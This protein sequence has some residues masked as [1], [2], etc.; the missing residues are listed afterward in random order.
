MTSSSNGDKLAAKSNKA[1]KNKAG[2]GLL[3]LPVWAQ[4]SA[5]ERYVGD[6]IG[7]RVVAGRWVRLMCQRHRRDLDNGAAR[8]LYFDADAAQDVLDWFDFLRHSK[9]EMAGEIISLEPWQQALLWVLFGWMGSDG[10]RRFRVSY[11][12]MARK[13]GKSTIAA[14]IGLYLLLGDGEP[15]AEVYSAAT[16]R[17]Q[18]KIVFE[19]A[20]RMVRS[21]PFL[22]KKI[23]A[24]RENLHIRDTASKFEA[25]GRDADTMDGLNPHGAILDELHAWRDGE[26][27]GVLET[28]MGARRQ[29]LMFAITTAG[30]NQDSYCFQLRDYACKV[31]DGIVEDD[32][33]FGVIYTLDEGDDWRNEATWIKANPNLGVSIQIDELRD[34][35]VKA[36]SIASTL[37]HFLTKRMNVWTNAA[38]LWIHPDKWRAC[39]GDFDAGRLAGRTCYGGLDLS[40]T[41]DLTAF[42][43]VFTP[44]EDDPV[45]RV[46]PFFWAPEETVRS[47]SRASRVPY[48]VW[49]RDGWMVEIPGEVIDYAY[50]YEQIG[51]AAGLY[52]LREVAFDRWGAAEVY[53][54]MAE[55]GLTMVQLGQG[56]QSMSPPM[57]ELERLITSKLL[58]HGNHPVLT[59]N[60]HNL[61]ATRDAAGNIKPDKRK[62]REKIDG[63]VALIMALDRAT[64]HN[65]NAGRSVYEER[66]VE[67][68]G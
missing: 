43:L 10:E 11:W 25:L 13:N 38:E 6:V 48:D 27:W 3:A 36:L 21:S 53:L 5:A 2:A 35:K 33:F 17:D 24:F 44:V 18:A 59:W 46:L 37:T 32:A 62:S 58:A 12:E 14:G 31:L 1:K 52:D 61:V 34:Q 66:G 4:R 16:K 67:E 39:G 30:F 23:T 68:V 50:I 64:R 19:E 47:K 29:P 65:A 45:W 40:N 26:V 57:K 42:V 63:G 8:G 9:G 7:G 56:M 15:G 20:K 54:R 51:A 60:M 41:L 28:G 22:R 55:Q 49:V